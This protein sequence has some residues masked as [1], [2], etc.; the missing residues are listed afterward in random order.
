MAKISIK[1]MSRD[2]VFY[3]R[4]QAF[5]N[6]SDALPAIPALHLHDRILRHLLDYGKVE[7]DL[8]EEVESGDPVAIDT[9]KLA[10]RLMR[11]RISNLVWTL[12]N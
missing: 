11:W 10:D 1:T 12:Y 2:A 9:C 3:W 7:I 8:Y 6:S 5:G 4:D